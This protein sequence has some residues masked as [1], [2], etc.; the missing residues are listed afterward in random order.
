MGNRK[1]SKLWEDVYG[2][3]FEIKRRRRVMY[4]KLIYL[5]VDKL[6]K[7]ADILDSCCGY[8]EALDVLF[9]MG[10][11]NLSGVDRHIP[12]ALYANRR[13]QVQTGDVRNLNYLDESFDLV[14][15][16]HAL[17]HLGTPGEIKQFLNECYRI[18]RPGGCLSMIDF[19]SSLQLRL[20]L[21]G[22]RKCLFCWT[23]RLKNLS[24]LIQE[25]WPFLK[26]YLSQW[27]KVHRFLHKGCFEVKSQKQTL[28]YFYL[29]L[30]KPIK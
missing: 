5:G 26:D 6:D 10:F 24:L 30:K 12:D 8:G 28:F 4:K 2:S 25:E 15:N 11:H 9:E 14:L 13:F 16:I 27:P 1:E 21:W 22:L 17:H 23:P 29:H 3:D 18:L 19:P 20:A 7:D